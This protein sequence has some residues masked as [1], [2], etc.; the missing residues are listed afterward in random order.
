MVNLI[1]LGPPGSGK[2]TQ[3]EILEKEKGLAKLSTGDMLRAA[4][5]AGTELGQ[6]AKSIMEA[7]ELVPDDL[8]VGL[9]KDRISNPD[10]KFG[11]IL[12]GFP[13]TTPQAEALD[14]MLA[15]LELKIDHTIEF[16]VDDEI[17]V[18][19]VSGRYSCAS[20]GAGYHDEF[21]KP[22][23]EGI[24]DNCG[25]SEFSRRKDDNAET[26]KTRLEAYHKQT[27][28]LSAYYADKGLLRKVDGMQDIDIV[29]GEVNKIAA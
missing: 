1:F 27:A 15:E 25:S 5:A 3:A 23:L 2:G 29:Q 21:K 14:V 19:R 28:P 12:D 7:G 8:M 18:K 16:E 11:F 22:Q 10:C 4:V 17:L 26:V 24:C 13:R 9:I 6:K 20:C